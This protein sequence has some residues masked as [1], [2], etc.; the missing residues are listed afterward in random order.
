MGVNLT[1]EEIYQ[2]TISGIEIR[3]KMAKVVERYRERQAEYVKLRN[4]N[5]VDPEPDM[6]LIYPDRG[7]VKGAIVADSTITDERPVRFLWF[8]LWWR[9]VTRPSLPKVMSQIE[10]VPARAA[11]ERQGE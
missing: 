8:T 9:R 6:P 11:I 2:S 7:E 10:S 5:R 3:Q 4:C 1:D